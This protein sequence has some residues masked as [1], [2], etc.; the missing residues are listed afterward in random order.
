MAALDHAPAVI[1]IPEVG[2]GRGI[3][4]AV[5]EAPQAATVDSEPD[6]LAY[7]LYTSG[8]T[9]RPKGVM[10]SHRN[11]QCFVDWCGN[12]LRPTSDDRFSSHAP[13]HFDLSILDV[14]TPIAHGGLLALI[15][16][17]LGK[18][19]GAL[20]R[21][22]QDA[23]L[24]VWYSTPSI[25]SLI[26]EF[27]GVEDLDLS[28]LRQV[29]FA[30]EVFPIAHLRRLHGQL[31][32]R[33]YLNLYGP[34]ETN[35]CTWY[36]LPREI[37]AERTE[38]YP[39]GVVCA[40]YEGLVVDLDDRPTT[41][42]EEGELLITGPGVM[43]G[44]WDLDEQTRRAFINIDGRHWY[45]TGDLVVELPD[46]NLEFH[47]RKDRMVKKRGYRVELG[48]I[49]AALYQHAEVREAA[50]VALP[51]PDGLV[52]RAHLTTR[53]GERISMIALKKFCADRLPVYMVPDQFRFH[54]ELP[55]TSTDKM[56]YQTLLAEE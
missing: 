18:D 35:V 46:G 27:G 53:D 47:G 20:A 45:R 30:G 22:I 28:T 56:D 29:I 8:S 25:L 10:I 43:Q 6:D 52:V 31:P 33:R 34:T 4:A 15:P 32:G 17:K 7:I 37:E 3:S 50:V 19:P 12:V 2:G 49:E 51:G 26:S 44:Y 24:T 41:P 16:E 40:H 54:A 1:A 48:E 21:F 13:L 11:A 39:I 14:Y 36:E 23:R 9:G 5:G 42:G 55:K 38:P